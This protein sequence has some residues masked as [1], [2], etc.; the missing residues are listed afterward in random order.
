[1]FTAFEHFTQTDPLPMGAG[2][3]FESPYVY[4]MNNPL[5]FTDPSGL[6]AT[7][8]AP[9]RLALTSNPIAS[10]NPCAGKTAPTGN[11][12][13]VF[14]GG[15]FPIPNGSTAVTNSKGELGYVPSKY[16]GGRNDSASQCT[17]TGLDVFRDS[18]AGKVLG[19]RCSRGWPRGGVLD[20]WTWG[21]CCGEFR[22]CCV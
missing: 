21:L 10:A 4:G 9:N 8:G 6:R 20:H 22:L 7:V 3:P 2:S 15:C 13:I 14:N 19:N 17:I 16:C 18:G 11:Y 12:A 5:V 1:M